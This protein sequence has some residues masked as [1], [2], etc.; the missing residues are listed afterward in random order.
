MTGL[1]AIAAALG[2]GTVGIFFWMFKRSHTRIDKLD[3]R[4]RC[5]M[6]ESRVRTIVDDKLAP[7]KAQNMDLSRRLGRLEVK[8]DRLIE[9]AMKK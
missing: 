2:M 6:S 1:E 5:A 7:M 9:L 3:D 4:L 8:I